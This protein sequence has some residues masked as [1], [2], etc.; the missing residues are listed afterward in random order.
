MVQQVFIKYKGLLYN[1]RKSRRKLKKFKSDINEIAKER[2]I[3]EGK[4]SATKVIQTLYK[5]REKFTKL[6][7]DYSITVS[8][9][10]YKKKFGEGLNILT[11]KHLVSSKKV[12]NNIMSSIKVKYKNGYYIYEI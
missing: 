2:N 11:T 3:S 1:T 8:E 12:Y 4:K 9:A 7:K 10:K 5:S 6:F